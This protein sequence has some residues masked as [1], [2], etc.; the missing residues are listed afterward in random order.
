MPEIEI[1]I[2]DPCHKAM[3]GS[4]TDIFTAINVGSH[5]HKAILVRQMDGWYLDS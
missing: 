3:L 2:L 1:E 4:Y 5:A